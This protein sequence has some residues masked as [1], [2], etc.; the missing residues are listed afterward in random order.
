M[1]PVPTKRF[2]VLD[3]PQPPPTVEPNASLVNA[4]SSIQVY[5]KPKRPTKS[6]SEIY[7]ITF[8][9]IYSFKEKLIDN[10]IKFLAIRNTDTTCSPSDKIDEMW[11]SHIL[12]TTSYHY[13]CMTHFGKI[14]HHS[15][16]DAKN[17]DKRKERLKRTIGL[18]KT[19]Y[20]EEADPEIWE[21]YEC[22]VCL[23]NKY[24]YEMKTTNCLCKI[25]RVCNTCVEKISKCPVCQRA[26][27]ICLI[28]KTLLGNTIY[29]NGVNEDDTIMHVKK[30]IEK[31]EHI[32]TDRQRLI[33][34]GMCYDDGTVLRRVGVKDGVTMHLVLR[35]NS[36]S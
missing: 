22:C 26:Y 13:Y 21:F 5:E 17:Q 16:S 1:L 19:N 2:F 14:V 31:M 33:Y 12:D 15:P 28:V 20:G 7:D 18:L 35:L 27:N 23:E 3:K 32:P 24:G 30:Q 36:T 4:K 9:T 34:G 10:Y 6:L 11:H 25:K 8:G 29:V